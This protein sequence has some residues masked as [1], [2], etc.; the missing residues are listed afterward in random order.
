M[1]KKSHLHVNILRELRWGKI[2]YFCFET[3]PYLVR[4]QYFKWKS[5]YVVII[6]SFLALSM[7]KEFL[8]QHLCV[9]LLVW[10]IF[11]I[12]CQSL[13]CMLLIWTC[14]I[15][16][17]RLRRQPTASPAGKPIVSRQNAGDILSIFLVSDLV[18][19]WLKT[20]ASELSPSL[21]SLSPGS[22]GTGTVQLSLVIRAAIYYPFRQTFIIQMLQ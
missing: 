4:L 7:F 14:K 8:A 19:G 18:E 13:E 22:S 3:F 11:F 1:S 20:N 12:G 10:S 5:F 2:P 15:S 21:T 17:W 9:V 6:V 16:S